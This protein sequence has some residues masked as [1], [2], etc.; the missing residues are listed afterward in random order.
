MFTAMLSYVATDVHPWNQTLTLSPFHR[1]IVDDLASVDRGRTPWVAVN[2]HRPIYTSSTAGV[3]PTSVLRVAEDLQQALESAFV[4]Y[5]V[6]MSSN[7]HFLLMSGTTQ[8]LCTAL[9]I[10]VCKILEHVCES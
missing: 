5:Q 9:Q 7:T 8:Y 2:M 4:L 6:P 10:F 3:I 1:F